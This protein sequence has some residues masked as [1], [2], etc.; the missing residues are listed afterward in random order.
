[1]V[2]YALLCMLAVY[3]ML[4]VLRFNWLA[5]Y[6]FALLDLNPNAK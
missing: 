1:M 3:V 6:L 4:Q 2:G 5:A